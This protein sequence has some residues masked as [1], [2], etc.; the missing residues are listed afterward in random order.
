MAVDLNATFS[1]GGRP[2]IDFL[3]Y[4]VLSIQMDP[5]FCY[6]ARDFKSLPSATK[7]VALYEA[8]CAPTTPARISCHKLLPPFDRRILN[9]I[10]PLRPPPPPERHDPPVSNDEEEDDDDDDDGS[11]SSDATG[12]DDAEEE[13]PDAE[14]SFIPPPRL[15]PSYL[16]D[17]IIGELERTSPSIRQIRQTYNPSLEPIENLPGG[18]LT[19]GQRIFVDNV[20][21]PQIRPFLVQA[22]FFRIANI[23]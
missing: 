5:V 15:P 16:F 6:L 7:A 22:G 23:A 4:C 3:E 9:D 18:Q 11:E 10:D 20:W 14:P 21:G 19:Q 1:S 12:D 2:L 13:A 17:Q 8:F